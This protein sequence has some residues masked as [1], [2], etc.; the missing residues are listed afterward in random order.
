[1]TVLDLIR[2]G[3]PEGCRFELSPLAWRSMADALAQAPEVALVALWADTA[4][5]H[6]LLLAGAPVI[7]SVAV[8]A[9]L[10]AALSPVATRCC[11]VR[12]DGRRPLGPP[13]GGC[14]GRAGLAGP[15][16]LAPAAA[17]VGAAGP[18][19]GAAGD[20]GDDGVGDGRAAVRPLGPGPVAAPG[21]WRVALKGG[22]VAG[23]EARFGY[24]HRGVL[25]LMRGK[26][27]S[28]AAAMAARIAGAATVAHATAFARA[29]EAALGVVPPP[30]GVALRTAMLAIERAAVALH[31][32]HA[33]LAGLGRSWPA[34]LV[35]RETL[36]EA[37]RIAFGHRLMMDAVRRAAWWAS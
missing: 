11:V 25:G 28:G 32:V 27:A 31:D 29:V 6:A 30:R 8:E 3:T 26:S 7:A 9:G 19:C 14:C 33:V 15:R 21:H 18:E 2:G 10:Y 37:C 16:H 23:L 24:G 22:R 13:G 17:A 35:L 4:R 1:M 12:A 36:L 5:V 20:A 34:G